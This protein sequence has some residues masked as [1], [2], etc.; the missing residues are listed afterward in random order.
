MLRIRRIVDDTRENDRSA[1]SQAQHIL[2][3]RFGKQYKEDDVALLPER[4]RDPV[5][6]G[7]RTI[8]LVADDLRGRVRAM[9]ILLY[10]TRLRFCYLDYI[11]TRSSMGRAESAKGSAGSGATGGLGAALYGR[12]REEAKTLGSIGVFFD[13]QSDDPAERVDEEDLAQAIRRLKF[14]E[15]FGARPLVNPEWPLVFDD[16]GQ[17]EPVRRARMRSIARAIMERHYKG[18][19][20]KEEIREA[21]LT[22]TDDP[23]RVRE[24]RYVKKPAKGPARPVALTP[25]AVVVLVVNDRHDIHHV[26]DRGY[27]ES[28]ARITSI[29][30]AITP[31]GLFRPTPPTQFPVSHITAVHD[32]G[33]VK[34]LQK[35]CES[36]APNETAY[37]SVFPL[38]SVAHPTGHAISHAGY[39][40]NDSFT[41]LHRN[42]YPAAKR[43]VDCVLTAAA[44]V[45]K[46][47]AEQKEP[48]GDPPM[49][50][51]LVRPPGHHAETRLFGGFCYFNNA[52]VAA[53]Y[54]V[55]SE[56]GARVAILDIDYHHG[57]GQ[58]EIF[59][60]RG[61][62]LTVS[63][64]GDPK[65]E[66]P[67][68]T[69]TPAETGEGEGKGCNVNIV[70]PPGT[71][72]EA[73]RKA[74]V[75][76]LKR[77][78][79]YAP[80][81]LI[82]ALGLDTARGDPTGSW[83][84]M[85]PDFTANGALIRGAGLPTVVVQEGGYRIRSVGAHARAFFVGLT[86]AGGAG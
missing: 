1:I 39:Y 12:V 64:H 62:V 10:Y 81:Y 36:L 67:Y 83:A 17:G 49:A 45:R 54:L 13:C 60:R 35:A 48:G 55:A 34:Y 72:G 37:A 38:R 51:A 40:C 70:L 23:V 44:A 41:P 14:Y 30:D 77:V 43:G 69:G 46:A 22:F 76:A 2:R 28:P 53:Q 8:L 84:L 59:Y 52:A 26:R 33:M 6:F 3:K 27:V 24:F 31:T 86:S 78:R 73:Y 25:E 85:A 66:Y 15:R 57:N 18:V 65:T 80:T 20:T 21:A 7:Y 56:P 61:D 79:A 47:V 75:V 29:M 68:F 4:L 9:A 19:R 82:V 50:Y 5:R 11:A 63:I 74:L 71:D 42:V 58:Q 16:L 32:A